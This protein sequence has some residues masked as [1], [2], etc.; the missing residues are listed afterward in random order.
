M[1]RYFVAWNL[2]LGFGLF[3]ILGKGYARQS[4]DYF[5]VFGWGWIEPSHFWFVVLVAA[6]ATAGSLIAWRRTISRAA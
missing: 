4:P 2:W 1:L 3:L 6:A 5:S